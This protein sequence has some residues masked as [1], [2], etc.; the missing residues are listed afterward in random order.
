MT[1]EGPDGKR[2]LVRRDG[3]LV[4][5]GPIRLNDLTPESRRIVQALIDAARSS[6]KPS[7]VERIPDS[8]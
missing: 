8:R 3:T 1:L 7:A 5:G 2:Y 6:R 4:T